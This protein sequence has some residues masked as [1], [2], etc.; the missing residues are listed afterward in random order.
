MLF[1]GDF[2]ALPISVNLGCP[3]DVLQSFEHM[4]NKGLGFPGGTA[5]QCRRQEFA[6]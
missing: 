3:C 4:K 5:W 1:M 6:P 2:E